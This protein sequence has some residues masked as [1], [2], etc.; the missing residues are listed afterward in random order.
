MDSRNSTSENN[1][2][3]TLSGE[4]QYKNPWINVTEY[5]IIN[6]NGGRGIYGKISF[7]NR[8][9][10]IIPI[11]EEGCT[12]LVGQFRYVLDAYSW[13]LPEGGAP[14]DE[15]PLEGA[16]RELREET[17]LLAENWEL[18]LRMHLSNSVSDEEG[19]VYVATGLT[20]TETDFDRT[21][22]LQIRRLPLAEALSMVKRGE[23][24]DSMT[25]AGLYALASEGRINGGV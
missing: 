2:W 5:Q 3:T 12:W 7:K 21:E 19:L 8:A 17:G 13:E 25:V 1:P 15:D 10:G 16:K 11:D 4:E 18:L 20:M 24:T 9:I 22:Q 23:I 14:L 6:P